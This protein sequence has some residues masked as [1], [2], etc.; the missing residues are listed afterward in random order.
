LDPS[1]PTDR[2]QT[3]TTKLH[4]TRSSHRAGCRCSPCRAAWSTYLKTRRQLDRDDPYISAEPARL[5]LEDLA[6]KG[7]GRDRVAV[8]LRVD[9]SRIQRIRNGTTT[10]LRAS[11]ALRILAVP[12]SHAGGTHRPAGR[13]RALLRWF[14]A[15]GFDPRDLA[16]RLGL[17][18]R[19]LAWTR[20]RVALSTELRLSAYRRR[21]AE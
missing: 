6:R 12:V 19:T 18:V 20:T 7:V 9:P 16:Q 8:L 14:A 10:R 13:F 5:Y 4:G 21:L 15:E 17:D 1:S 3:S 2:R 11:L